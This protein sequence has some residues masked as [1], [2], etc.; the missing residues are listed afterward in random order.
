ML[1]HYLIPLA[2][3]V[4]IGIITVLFLSLILCLEHEI[5]VMKLRWKRGQSAQESITHKLKAQVSDLG[6]RMLDTE[7]RCGVLV[8]PIPPKSGLNLN[9]RSQ[10]IRMSQRGEQAGK[11]AASL[12][13]P[14]REVELLLKV[15]GRVVSS[16]TDVNS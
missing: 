9:K 14:Q 12:N 15:Y 4:L 3:F 10:V 11:I 1:D 8:P 13:L 7:Q 6:A 2:P 5:R 16:S